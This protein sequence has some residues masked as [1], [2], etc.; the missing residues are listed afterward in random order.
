MASARPS[1][2]DKSIKGAA[3]L[4]AFVILTAI[5]TN[6]RYNLQTDFVSFWAAA[7]LALGGNPEAA[8]DLDLHKAVEMTA[9]AVK[10]LIPFPYPPTYL[11][12][13]LPFG[14][15][16]YAMAHAVWVGTTLTA[17]LVVAHKLSANSALLAMAFP[18]VILCGIGGQNSFLMAAIFMTAMTL[19]KTRPFIAGLVFG[20]LAFKPH[21][22]LLLPIALIAGRDWRTFAGAAV[23]TLG[24]ILLS[25]VVFGPESWSGFRTLLPLA[26]SI[27]SE[28][29]VSWN[30]MASVY[31]S[32]RLAGVPEPLAWIVHALVAV[33]AIVFL[34]RA[35]RTSTDIGYRAAALAAATLLISPYLFIYDQLL[36]VPALVYLWQRGGHEKWLGLIYAIAI[37]SL[38]GNF[39]MATVVSVAPLLPTMLIALIWHDRR[40]TA[41]KSSNGFAEVRPLSAPTA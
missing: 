16:P 39:Y 25:F 40:L 21:L 23:S 8:Y 28:G 26:G 36:L 15:L 13:V 37:L 9:V 19:M 10:G 11:L 30:K 31:A 27:A 3:I 41:V 5:C 20:L 7:K 34:W 6:L 38:A 1:T 18:P 24:L 33:T 2:F 17:Y 14:L 4:S 32:L 35:W 22:G 12:A 29:L